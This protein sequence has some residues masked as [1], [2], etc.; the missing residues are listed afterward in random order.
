[1]F[2]G[3][4]AGY[5]FLDADLRLVALNGAMAVQLGIAR[6]AAPGRRLEELAP[7][8]RG[9]AA[10]VEDVLRAGRRELDVPEEADG[11]SWMLT[12]IPLDAPAGGRGAAVVAREVTEERTAAQELAHERAILA[13]VIEQVPVGIAVLWGEEQRYV[14]STRGRGRRFPPASSPWALRWR[15]R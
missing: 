14:P 10:V 5:A 15:R 8:R 12:A 1:M 7:R 3:L 9:L 4:P 13:R 6:E 2:E 11:R